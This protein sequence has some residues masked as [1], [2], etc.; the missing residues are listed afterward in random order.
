MNNLH[1]LSLTDWISESIRR[2]ISRTD[3]LGGFRWVREKSLFK[4]MQSSENV[5]SD[6]F[7]RLEPTTSIAVCTPIFPSEQ[8]PPLSMKKTAEKKSNQE[9][10]SQR[11]IGEKRE[12]RAGM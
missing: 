9:D 7:L 12:I 2:F 4:K 1:R 3:S 11:E 5:Y 6:G 10:P 8:I